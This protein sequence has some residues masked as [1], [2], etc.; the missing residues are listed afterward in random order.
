MSVNIDLKAIN[1]LKRKAKALEDEASVYDIGFEIPTK[2]KVSSETKYIFAVPAENNRLRRSSVFIETD[3]SNDNNE[4]E[5]TPL[6]NS[7]KTK[8]DHIGSIENFA[9]NNKDSATLQSIT[10]FSQH[11]P[12]DLIVIPST[13]LNNTLSETSQSD[14]T[15]IQF[16]LNVSTSDEQSLI[17]ILS[18]DESETF[19]EPLLFRNHYFKIVSQQNTFVNAMCVICGFDEN[20]Q[21]KKILKAQKNVSSNFISH[22]KVN[23][24]FS[25]Y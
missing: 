6:T 21:P 3:Q 24:I 10:Q 25:F 20:N 23:V 1:E 18:N 11:S 13:Q 2:K 17:Q 15:S 19:V 5:K 12:I 14:A 22:L 16:P 4:F 9:C 7:K 8:S